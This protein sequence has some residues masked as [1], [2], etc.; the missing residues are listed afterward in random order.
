MP[1]LAP[2]SRL[3][4]VL[5]DLYDSTSCCPDL[6]AKAAARQVDTNELKL[7]EALAK[8]RHASPDRPREE[9]LQSKE[10]KA[11]FG[12][13]S[14]EL[15]GGAE[16]GYGKELVKTT[17]N[18]PDRLLLSK[19]SE[20][21]H[22]FSANKNWQLLVDLNGQLKS[23]DG[24]LREWGDFKKEAL[25]LNQQYN[26]I[27]LR[28]EYNAAVASSQMA[29]KWVSFEERQDE[30]YLRFD[31]A[32]DRRVRPAHAVLDG[33]TLPMVDPF[34]DKYWPPL[35]WNCRCDATEVLTSRA[36]P[37]DLQQRGPMPQIAQGFLSNTAKS[38]LVFDES[39]PYFK[40]VP[41]ADTKVLRQVVQDKLHSPFEPDGLTQK[42]GVTLPKEFFDRMAH[43]VP[44]RQS[45][46]DR[47]F[48]DSQLKYIEYSKTW[49]GMKRTPA[50][51]RSTL[52]H[53]LGHAYHFLTGQITHSTVNDKVKALFKEGNQVVAKLSADQLSLFRSNSA[54]RAKL[55]KEFGKKHSAP[56]IERYW[57]GAADTLAALT[58][59]KEGFGHTLSY[60][61]SAPNR[62]YM[63]MFAGATDVAFNGNPIFKKYLP[64]IY[65]QFQQF[66]KDEL[67]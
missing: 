22:W 64:D 58:K 16:K 35:D 5:T 11:L 9:V 56:E 43:K 45:P 34:W 13:V 46:G 6:E 50:M 31:T 49:S 41:A 62:T 67:K 52:V 53:E 21:L 30:T 36:K 38:G 15:M 18:D 2:T 61:N 40:G 24:K 17:F 27:W 26:T 57:I 54:N 33:I 51:V 12:Y 32:G 48:Y 20:N 4:D 28:T 23:A 25:K 47:S 55:Q 3:I 37:T 14:D 63:E 65:Q 60:W 66:W 39:H 10:W 1:A 29:A 44:I 8:A 42:Y 7:F 19:L 59:G